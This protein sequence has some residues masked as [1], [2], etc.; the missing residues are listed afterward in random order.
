MLSLDQIQKFYSVMVYL[1]TWYLWNNPLYEY[2]SSAA[3][4]L[5]KLLELF[6]TQSIIL[7]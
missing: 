5:G 3:L 1:A 6:T 2:F 4:P 7:K